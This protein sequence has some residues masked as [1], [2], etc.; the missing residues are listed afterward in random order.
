MD[1]EERERQKRRQ[2]IKVMIAEIGMVV[3]IVAVVVV[4]TLASMGFFVS[5]DGSIEQSG[6]IQI[7]SIPTGATVGLDGGVLFSRTNLSRMLTP[8][9]H[10]LKISRDGYDS[11]SK[12]VQIYSGLLV[13]LYYPRLFLLGRTTE[14]VLNLGKNL[15]F[16]SI[17][18]DYT[19]ALYMN[20]KNAVWD[21]LSI[22]G[23][24]V[25]TTSLD[26]SKVLPSV[27]EVEGGGT[28][29]QEE[30]W[31]FDGEINAAQWSKDNDYVLLDIK[32]A[33]KREWIL[34]NLKNS[35]ESLN[36]TEIFG[37]NFDKI[38]MIDGSANQL[39]ALENGHLR[40]IKTSDQSISRVLLDDL[41]D[42]MSDGL[43]I[44][45]VAKQKREVEGDK[46]EEKVVG[47]YRDGE[48]AG[49]VI[50]HTDKD[51]A[52]KIGLSEYYGENYI[53]FIINNIVTVY[54]GTIPAYRDNYEETDFAGMKSLVQDVELATIPDNLVVSIEGEYFVASKDQ[55]V[56]V[57]DVDMGDLYEYEIEGGTKVG[58]LNEAMMYGVKDGDLK[59]WDFDFTNQRLLV[60]KVDDEG[61]SI[62]EPVAVGG[63]KVERTVTTKT[64]SPVLPYPVMISSDNKWLYYIVE[65]EKGE[66]VLMREKVRD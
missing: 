30:V 63:I 34:V 31:K 14:A 51:S 52:V 4:S 20:N 58:W 41:V 57:I 1:F 47:V 25:Q 27:H 29:G 37:L 65:T 36:L 33:E 43:N 22:K 12:S 9:E 21:F 46:V 3:A 61:S 6:L 59:V 62:K 64:L 13:R 17:S 40:K 11:W 10:D 5:S 8:G 16:Y 24:E 26:L 45:Y 53:M 50:A 28:R 42:F 55:Q 56:M 66:A 35:G 2:F 19:N 60:K 38:E 48:K 15:N 49:T 54:Y 39:F 44:V 18:D 32:I 23:D 7:H